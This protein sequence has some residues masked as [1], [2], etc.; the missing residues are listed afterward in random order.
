MTSEF[1]HVKREWGIEAASY[2]A[3]FVRAHPKWAQMSGAIGSGCDWDAD[4]IA[5]QLARVARMAFSRIPNSIMPFFMDRDSAALEPFRV[6]SLGT[7]NG[8]AEGF[9]VSCF[10]RRFPRV[11]LITVDW[12][13]PCAEFREFMARSRAEHVHYYSISQAIVSEFSV[14]GELRPN[15]HFV[16]SFNPV[17]I[18]SPGSAMGAQD[19]MFLRAF[20]DT[21][22]ATGYTP[23]LLG[24]NAHGNKQPVVPFSAFHA[25]FYPTDEDL[26]IALGQVNYKN[27]DNLATRRPGDYDHPSLQPHLRRER[28]QALFDPLLQSG[29]LIKLPQGAFDGLLQ[30][31]QQ[32]RELPEGPRTFEPFVRPQIDRA[33]RYGIESGPFYSE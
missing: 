5:E 16:F 8:F 21:M 24:V 3:A 30:L 23:G 25:P 19:R 28:L 6:L 18:S 26:D 29:A 27:P 17:F 11:R 7:G 2:A 33:S 4:C 13:E 12:S 1:F 15:V 22:E 31:D 32:S 20:Y 14:D 10:L 9:L